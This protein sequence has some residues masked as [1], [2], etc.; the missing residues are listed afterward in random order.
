[1]KKIQWLRQQ[2]LINKQCL[3]KYSSI[4]LGW[5]L[6]IFMTTGAIVLYP[7]WRHHQKINLQW[8][9]QQQQLQ[10][11]SKQ[12]A[13]QHTLESELAKFN[14]QQSTNLI[15]THLII[16]KKHWQGVL[17]QWLHQHHIQVSQFENN[18]SPDDNQSEQYQLVAHSNWLA[19][20][21]FFNRLQLAMP[22]LSLQQIEL[23]LDSQHPTLITSTVD[24]KVNHD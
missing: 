23:S 16:Q 10:I 12:A 1:M 22:Y 19:F 17:L 8:H 2:I 15:T 11:C 4:W 24:I 3:L 7:A 20:V 18:D 9:T 14:R 5:Q 21:Y 6:V 13:M